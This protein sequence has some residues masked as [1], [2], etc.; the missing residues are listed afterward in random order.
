MLLLQQFFFE[1]GNPSHQ[2]SNKL[3]SPCEVFITV[4]I[5]YQFHS[6]E[7][8]HLTVFEDGEAILVALPGDDF[9]PL[10]V[11]YCRDKVEGTVDVV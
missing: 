11:G 4:A 9:D 1:L 8:H 6:E 2:I 3:S 10:I 7:I 5:V